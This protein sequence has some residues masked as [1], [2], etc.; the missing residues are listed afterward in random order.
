MLAGDKQRILAAAR[1]ETSEQLREQAIH[2]LGSMGE[3]GELER[4]Y[5]GERSDRIKAAILDGFAM[6][7]DKARILRAAREEPSAELRR[8]AMHMLGAL[9]GGDELWQMFQRE[10]SEEIKVS[11]L[12]G[13]AMSGNTDR[14]TTV[15]RGSG[16]SPAI[17]EAAIQ[18]L[19]M[20]DAESSRELF[21]SLYAGESDRRLKAALIHGLAMSSDAEGLIGVARRE[22]DQ[23]LR[24]EAVRWIAELDSPEAT[25]YMLEILEQD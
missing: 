11:I 2:F 3:T 24:T 17:R 12:E 8:R 13:L 18:G 4:L 20:A 10:S 6:A 14:L 16:F 9:D 23:E 21:R 1:G 25:A 19:A 7:G 15:V 5:A 22:K